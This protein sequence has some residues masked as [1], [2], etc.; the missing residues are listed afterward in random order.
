MQRP[1]RTRRPK[2]TMDDGQPWLASHMSLPRSEVDHLVHRILTLGHMFSVFPLL[3]LLLL[4]LFFCCFFFFF[5]FYWGGVVETCESWCRKVN[6]NA[7]MIE[8]I[9]GGVVIVALMIC[10]PKREQE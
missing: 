10:M 1:S 6:V 5:Y 2:W 3:I 4:L 9:A 8:S 7:L